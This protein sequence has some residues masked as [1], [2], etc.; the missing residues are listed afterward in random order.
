MS[1]QPTSGAN[2]VHTACQHCIRLHDPCNGV[3]T[4]DDECPELA[5]EQ[6]PTNDVRPLH[7][8]PPDITDGTV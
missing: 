2:S 5:P 6:E 7:E 1:N 3:Y 8:L 4:D